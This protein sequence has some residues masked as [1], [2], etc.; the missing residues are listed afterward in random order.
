MVIF[1]KIKDIDMDKNPLLAHSDAPFGAPRFDLY[2]NDMYL[3]AF[4]EA[5]ALY[6]KEI[7]AIVADE[8]EPS[9]GNTILAL[10]YA[11]EAL[12][13]VE[14]IFFNL[15][16]ADTDEQKQAIA[17]EISPELTEMG[18]YISLNETLFSKVKHVYGNHGELGVSEMRLLE[19]TY[20]S[21]VRSGA[22]LEGE[23]REKYRTLEEELSLLELKYGN[24]VLAAT[25][26]Y[27][28]HL[29]AE[30]DLAG[31]P[32]YVKDAGAQTAKEKGLEGWA[33]TL[34]FPSF[35]PFMKYST[36]RDL[37]EQ[38]W[39]VYNSKALGGVN[40]NTEVIREIVGHRISISNL[41]GYATYAD[42]ALER[43]M[44]KRRE[45]VE[46]FLDSLMAPSLPVARK[47]LAQILAYARKEGFE[48]DEL[49]PWD[50]PY[51]SEKW[52]QANYQIDEQLLKPYFRLEDCIAAVLGLATSLYG[53]T[54]EERSDIPVY[55][56]DVKVYDVKDDKGA[57]LALFYADFFPRESKRG[58]AWMTAFREQF[59][60]DGKDQRPFISIV[61]NFSKPTAEDPSLLT[62]GELETFLHEF[63]HSLHGMLS[64]GVY[65][66]QCGTNVARDFVELPS[67]IMENWAYEPE[68]LNSFARHYRTGDPIPSEYIQRI[69]EAKNCLSGY[70]QV[71]QLHFGYLDMAWHTLTEVPEVDVETFEKA[72][73]EPYRTLIMVPCSAVST[74]FGHIF[75][76]GYSA[77]Y[78]SY[79]WAEVLEADAFELFQQKGLFGG[80]AADSFR[81][82]IL[83]RG[84]S[85]D[86]SIL[87][88]RFRGRQPEPDAL[89][90]KLGII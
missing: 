87:Y 52:K 24:N 26:A 81:K 45:T 42:Y 41:L 7:D 20:L 70:L 31:L 85:E 83:E 54:F 49:M 89:L 5:I 56:K 86:E 1:A 79:K 30:E 55:H 57:H 18:M 34:H 71:R 38:M 40:D 58:G 37:R 14:G 77:G 65:P 44:A 46:K 32:D 47:E 9:F 51:W 64:K 13:N 35:S 17:E 28:L 66:S 36:R 76:G 59:C 78:Y 43:R 39:K 90:K 3:P 19:D 62:H 2:T 33:F 67:Q 80:E 68:F 15:L 61:T 48:G 25:N 72:V 22:A 63:G 84:S 29:D 12:R 50:F 11:G 82:N 21:F 73:L 6:K 69:V 60:K 27:T 74:S 75:S 53:I 23:D 8:A 88:E 4:R 10:E 16:E